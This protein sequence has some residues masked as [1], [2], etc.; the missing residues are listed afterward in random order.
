MI[1]VFDNLF[2][3]KWVT[4]LASQLVTSE[5][6]TTSNVA[7]RKTW[8]H[9][10]T[11]SHRLFGTLYFERKNEDVIY[12]GGGQGVRN[13]LVAAFDFLRISLKL[14]LLLTEICS[15]LQF[16]GMDGTTHNDGKENEV[17]FILMLC[18]EDLPK[19]IG[20][21]FYHQPTHKKYPFK[22]GRLIQIT[23]SDPHFAYAFKKPHLARVSIKFVG[24]LR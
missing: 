23:A 9:R 7:N 18:N 12:Y 4:W 24:T 14:N 10:E 17:S 5:S 19:N 11:G 16:M 21:E 13:E 3:Q 20:G 15:N 1:K 6:W 2:D 22:N 8:P